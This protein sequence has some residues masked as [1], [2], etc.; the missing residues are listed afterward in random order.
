MT[1]RRMRGFITAGFAGVSLLMLTAVVGCGGGA[2]KVDPETGKVELS[3][4]M[5]AAPGV[6][7]LDQEGPSPP[8]D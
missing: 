5:N 2:S 4:V 7:P 8:P 1:T 6:V 3:P